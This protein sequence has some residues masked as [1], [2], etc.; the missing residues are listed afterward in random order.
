LILV[1]FSLLMLAAAFG[2]LRRRTADSSPRDFD[3]RY[4]VGAWLR[5]V[6]VG[7]AV[8]FLTGFFGMGGGFLIVPALVL[9]LGLPLHLAV[10]TS[11]LVIA[12]NAV[13]GLLGNLRFGTLDWTLT[14]LFA[15]SG[16]AGV[17]AGGRLSGRLPDRALRTAFA[18]IVVG[19]AIY[20]FGSN[21][22]ALVTV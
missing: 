21:V 4:A 1:L 15:A 2:M 16:A 20:T 22:M 9:V 12:L 7:L 13:W 11:L 3:E 19:V 18:L 6:L 8:G 5:L 17:L 14:L 10:G